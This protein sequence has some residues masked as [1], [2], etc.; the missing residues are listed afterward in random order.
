MGAEKPARVDLSGLRVMVVQGGV[1]VDMMQTYRDTS[2]YQDKG[3]K[4][5]MLHPQGESWLIA[6]EDWSAVPK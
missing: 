3:V 4:T 5:V 2:G 6:S 1:K